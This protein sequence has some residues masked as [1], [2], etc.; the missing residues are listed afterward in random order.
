MRIRKKIKSYFRLFSPILIPAFV[1]LVFY[2]IARLPFLFISQPN[3]DKANLIVGLDG[4]FIGVLI[5]IFTIYVSF[6]LSSKIR[7]RFLESKHQRIFIGHI[8]VGTILYT[9]SIFAY[10]L[11]DQY[12]LVTALFF[13]G[14]SNFF[15]TAYYITVLV[16]YI[17]ELI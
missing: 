10:L 3:Q 15:V 17:N 2:G 16:K 13:M 5:T 12:T 14:M 6:P 9:I 4:T 11:F 8:W 7:K 1:L